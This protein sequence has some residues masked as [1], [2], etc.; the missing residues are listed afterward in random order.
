M[1]F[2]KPDSSGNSGRMTVFRHD[3]P[4]DSGLTTVA[5]YGFW[6]LYNV[7]TGVM[8]IYWDAGPSTE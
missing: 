7:D 3:F 5:T 4:V 1:A 8:K 2:L 6:S